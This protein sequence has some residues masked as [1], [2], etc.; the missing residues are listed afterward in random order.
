MCVCVH[1]LCKYM[2]D[3][4]VN[5]HTLYSLSPPLGLF[6]FH[7]CN[8]VWS[9]RSPLPASQTW[10]ASFMRPFYN[11][12]STIDYSKDPIDVGVVDSPPPK[13]IYWHSPSPSPL[14]GLDRTC[15]P[16]PP[17]RPVGAGAPQWQLWMDARPTNSGPPHV[18]LWGAPPVQPNSGASVPRTKVQYITNLLPYNEA[19]M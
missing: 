11:A 1:T 13:K 18:P 10:E 9:P 2:L 4:Y 17:S 6:C 14:K 5:F 8:N 7:C 3:M 19:L 12:V 16:K 15:V